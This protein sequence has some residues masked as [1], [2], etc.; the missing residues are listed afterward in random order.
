MRLKSSL[1]LGLSL[2][3][4]SAGCGDRAAG[5]ETI[6]NTHGGSPKAA[7]T[8]LRATV[9]CPAGAVTIIKGTDQEKPYVS[10]D[11]WPFTETEDGWAQVQV[12]CDI[13][14]QVLKPL[15]LTDA[16]AVSE[17]GANSQLVEMNV[18]PQNNGTRPSI[19]IESA[20][21]IEVDGIYALNHATVVAG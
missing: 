1:A 17:A 21:T 2:A 3:T 13:G 4:L 6:K 16:A 10:N 9:V 14:R 8:L 5:P 12:G 15:A 20:D 18:T 19:Y 11:A 7:Q